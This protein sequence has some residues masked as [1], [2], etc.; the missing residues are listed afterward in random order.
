MMK[1]APE[2]FVRLHIERPAATN[3]TLSVV[4]IAQKLT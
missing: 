3:A 2:V 4:Q 1:I